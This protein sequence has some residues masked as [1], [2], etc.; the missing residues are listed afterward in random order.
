MNIVRICHSKYSGLFS[1]S[2]IRAEYYLGS[3]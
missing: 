2:V 1:D 3:Y